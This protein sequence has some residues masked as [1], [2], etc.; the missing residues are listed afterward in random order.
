MHL[1]AHEIKDAKEEIVPYAGIAAGTKKYMKH[2][3][4]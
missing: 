1:K 4:S 3:G 2:S